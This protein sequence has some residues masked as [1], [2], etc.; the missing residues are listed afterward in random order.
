MTLFLALWGVGILAAW[1]LLR[2]AIK[3]APVIHDDNN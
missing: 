2:R 3:R 1:L